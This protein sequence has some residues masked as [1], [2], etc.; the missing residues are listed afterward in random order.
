MKQRRCP[1]LLIISHNPFSQEKNNGKTLLSFF[2]NWEPESLA[3]FFITN[4][5]PDTSVCCRFFRIT[6]LEILRAAIGINNS[7]GGP[8]PIYVDS[9]MQDFTPQ[10]SGGGTKRLIKRRPQWL[11]TVRDLCWDLGRWKTPALEKWLDEFMPEVVFMQCSTPALYNIAFWI[12]DRY[13]I[14]YFLEITDDY[15]SPK[16]SLNPFFWIY[17]QRMRRQMTMAIQRAEKV[18]VIGEKMRRAYAEKYGGTYQIAMN[19]VELTEYRLP[20]PRRELVKMVYTGN[21]GVGRWKTIEKLGKICSSVPELRARVRLEIY[22]GTAVSPQIQ[23]RLT[24]GV[25]TFCGKL[26]ASEVCRIQEDSDIL[27]HVESFKEKDRYITRYSISTK[28]GEYLARGR[29]ILALGPPDVASIEYLRDHKLGAV[30]TSTKTDV[31][32]KCLLDLVNNEEERLAYGKRAYEQARTVHNR[33]VV[34]KNIQEIIFS[35]TK[36]KG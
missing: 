8:L 33:T 28:I 32:K 12:C 31:I 2:S 17:F 6:D 35:A 14:P 22:S 18:L 1:R 7:P 29:C 25:M 24:K 13:K 19:S 15:L 26:S 10:Y 16:F 11:V 27:L 30:L 20:I 9:P 3:Q 21:L 34:Q 36:W 4:E 23:E 5:L